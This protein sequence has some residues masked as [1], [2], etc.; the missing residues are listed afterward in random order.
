MNKLT[1]LGAS[2]LC[3]SLAAI[4]AANAGE[5]TVT[6][7][8]DMSW[9]SLENETTG[10][11]IG[12][13]SNL[14]FKGSGELDNGTTFALTVAN[15]N[16]Q[17]YSNT[18]VVMTTPTMGEFRIDHGT[19]GTGLDAIDD[20]MPTAWEEPWCTAVGT[21]VDLVDGVASG[22]NIQWTPPSDMLP[23]GI[24]GTLTWAPHASGKNAG[25][26]T[27]SGDSGDNF[28]SGWDIVTNLDM[29]N[30]GMDGLTLHAGMSQIEYTDQ[31][32]VNTG[33]RTEYSFAAVYAVSNFTIGYQETDENLNAAAGGGTS[34]YDNTMYGISFNVNDD[35]TVS[36]GKTESEKDVMGGTNVTME[37]TSLQLAY[38]VGG[39]SIRLAETSA[40]NVAYNT[41]A[42]EDN[43]GTTLSVSLAF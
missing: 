29:G 27:G 25:D 30:F 21:G 24:S 26:K 16:A 14:T 7:G 10:N 2:A 20:K 11:P 4:S 36:Y 8:V 34:N 33:D 17:G 18:N 31:A 6:G 32:R 39:A 41:A 5:L 23:G 38:T 19:S 43:D 1:K 15:T 9:V 28:G 22:T 42:G 13:G 3:G 40:D 35:L 37:A 12:M